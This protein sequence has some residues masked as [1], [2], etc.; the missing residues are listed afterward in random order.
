MQGSD[1][2]IVWHFQMEYS[3]II[4]TNYDNLLT[5]KHFMP[6]CQSA[7]PKWKPSK[8]SSG[9]HPFAMDLTA[10]TA[11]S[12]VSWS[13]T[14]PYSTIVMFSP[15]P[16][17]GRYCCT[18]WSTFTIPSL[19]TSDSKIIP[20]CI[21]NKNQTHKKEEHNFMANTMLWVFL[22]PTLLTCNTGNPNF[23]LIKFLNSKIIVEL[24]LVF[25]CKIVQ[26]S[27][28][29]HPVALMYMYFLHHLT[30]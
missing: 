25:E 8:H 22:S 15:S 29:I 1:N 18:C 2:Y 5:P 27:A 23:K 13:P 7:I 14:S 3:W 16:S 11:R 26:T 24:V 10:L 30:K 28:L 19:E 17:F 12:M 21:W 20:I 6:A 4:Y 9:V